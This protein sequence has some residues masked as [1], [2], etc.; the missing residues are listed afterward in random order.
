MR[1]PAAVLAAVSKISYTVPCVESCLTTVA[2]R[3][4]EFYQSLVIEHPDKS[5]VCKVSPDG[6]EAV[7]LA[8]FVDEEIGRFAALAHYGE[9]LPLNVGTGAP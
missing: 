5:C 7:A 1:P 9:D 3:Y 2:V 8:R 6:P 4:S